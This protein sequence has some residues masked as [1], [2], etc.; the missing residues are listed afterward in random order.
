MLANPPLLSTADGELHPA[1]SHNQRYLH[2]VLLQR[3]KALS[4][5][6]HPQS[7][8]YWK[9]ESSWWVSLKFQTIKT[10]CSVHPA[11]FCL[12]S[13]IRNRVTGVYEV[14]LCNL[15]DA[16]SPGKSQDTVSVWN[17]PELPV[18]PLTLHLFQPRYA[19][20]TQAGAGHL[21]GLRP[22]G[23]EPGWVEASQ[24]QPHSGPPVGAGETQPPSRCEELM[25]LFI[26]SIL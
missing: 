22:W 24:W 23:G 3:H 14:S 7:F 5:P 15:A 21:S 20:E 19:E 11:D 8:R 12:F 26:Y 1:R 18:L 6:L 25:L 10:L 16:G 17:Y 13:F 4:L 9:P 2:G